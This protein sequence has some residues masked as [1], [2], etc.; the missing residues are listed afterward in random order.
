[1]KISVFGLGEASSL[2]SAD[3]AAKGESV[4]GF[5]PARVPTPQGVARVDDPA[6]AV[7]GADVVIAITQGSEAIVAIRQA[8]NDIPTNALYADFSSNSPRVKVTLA[9]IA[10]GRSLDFVD[11]ALMGTVPGKGIRT[12]ALASG[13][14]V[15]RFVAAFSELGMPVTE[16][17]ETAGEAATRKLLRSIMVKGLAGCL[18]EAMRAAE[19]AGCAEWLWNNLATEIATADESLLTRLVHGSTIHAARRLHEMEA[20]LAML[21]ELGVDDV[22]TQGTVE[23]LRRI[24]RQG[25][26][27]IPELED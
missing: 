17:S 2:I 22:M 10:A 23:N 14:G 11:I 27:W 9:D 6:Q 4:V 5:D 12:P 19:K 7:Q 16:V 8:L 20:S 15:K 24:P 3:L 21:E 26:P 1:M 13:G 25:L 18:I